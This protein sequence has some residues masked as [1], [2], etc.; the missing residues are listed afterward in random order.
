MR[1]AKAH[2]SS[3]GTGAS[4]I[5]G[6]VCWIDVSSTDPAGSRDFYGGLFGWT[7]RIDPAAGSASPPCVPAGRWPAWQ[8]LQ[9]RRVT[10]WPGLC[11]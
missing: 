4:F 5:P 9:C 7:Y 1:T 3:L 8:A 11:I 2:S 6:S 10:S